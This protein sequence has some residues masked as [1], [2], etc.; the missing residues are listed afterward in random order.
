VRS[1]AGWLTRTFPLVL[2][3]A[4]RNGGGGQNT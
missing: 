3:E 1:E 4:K 2:G